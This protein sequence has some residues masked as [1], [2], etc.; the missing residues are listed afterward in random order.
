MRLD[1]AKRCG[2]T[3]GG[4]FEGLLQPIEAGRSVPRRLA[5]DCTLPY[6]E[7]PPVGTPLADSIR[8]NLCK[9]ADTPNRSEGDEVTGLYQGD[10]KVDE[11]MSVRERDG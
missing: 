8:A 11:D 1:R 7:I 9:R 2:S 3:K 6:L 5:D 10:L 4:T